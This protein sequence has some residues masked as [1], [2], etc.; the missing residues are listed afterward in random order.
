MVLQENMVIIHANCFAWTVKREKYV[1]F[2][3]IVACYIY[4]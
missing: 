1:F 2:I 3:V 4:P